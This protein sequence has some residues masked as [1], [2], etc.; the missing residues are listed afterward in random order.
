MKFTE[1]PTERN[2]RVKSAWHAPEKGRM[3]A[4]QLEAE[5]EWI[6]TEIHKI[7]LG[8][9]KIDKF[10]QIIHMGGMST[11]QEW[12]YCTHLHSQVWIITA[13]TYLSKPRF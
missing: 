2:L 11:L 13:G 8:L 6:T 3:S 10:G 1:T 7:G 5:W 9:P 4:L 12:F